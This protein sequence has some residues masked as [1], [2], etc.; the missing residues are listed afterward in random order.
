MKQLTGTPALPTLLLVPFLWLAGCEA[1]ESAPVVET[2]EVAE[3]GEV[4]HAPWSYTGTTGPA[5]WGSLNPEFAA[6]DAGTTQSPINLADATGTDL[7]DL[8]FQYQPTPLEITNKVHTLQVDYAPGSTLT[9]EDTTYRLLQFHFHT[10]SEH[11]LG[12]E[13]LPMELH[14][15][16]QGPDG[17]LAVVG[18]MIRSGAELEAVRP[19]WEHLPTTPNQEK[20]V[21][22]VT[23]NAADL[24]PTGR[25]YYR[26]PG[27]LTTPPCTE[28][29]KWFVLS[30]PIRM[31]DAQIQAMRSIVSTSNRPVQPLGNRQLLLES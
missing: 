19:V 2:A 14:L 26:Y 30:E 22:S 7:P 9:V 23:V 3:T 13:E 24:L 6:C 11:R 25:S 27:S 12:G 1:E 28:G 5:R 10:P 16:H 4:E 20:Q 15:V 17:G 21:A 31:S 29:V 18:V 8:A